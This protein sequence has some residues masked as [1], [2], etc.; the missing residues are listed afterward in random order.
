[1]LLWWE[2]VV[3]WCRAAVVGGPWS[4]G[5]L[6]PCRRAAVV[7]W[8]EQETVLAVLEL[9]AVLPVLGVP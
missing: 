8:W 9:L 1:V 6:L 4:P 2:A 3:P 7:L 5:V